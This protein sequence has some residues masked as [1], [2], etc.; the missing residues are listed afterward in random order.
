MVS[1]A[2]LITATAALAALP[3]A[4]LLPL[5]VLFAVF[6]TVFSLHIGVERIGRY[7]QVFLED[8]H[9]WEHTAM[10]F[11]KPLRGTRVDPLFTA[12]FLFAT[13]LNFI[14]VMFADPPPVALELEV[15]G[16]IHVL[17]AIRFWLARRSAKMQRQA[18]LK[19]FL[20]LKAA[21]GGAA[22]PG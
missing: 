18:D 22:L 1:W 16:G 20:E 12:C 5:L 19:R 9:G 13:L 11:G 15:V 2:A 4:T 7:I 21:A 6:E 17:V 8:E 10:A 3:V 14:P